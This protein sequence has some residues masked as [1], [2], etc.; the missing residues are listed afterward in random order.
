MRFNSVILPL[1]ESP[2]YRL[3]P[4][5]LTEIS[6]RGPMSGHAIRLPAQSVVDGSRF[7]VVAGR[8]EVKQWWRSFRRP[9]PARLVRAGREYDVMGRL[10]AGSERSDA[11]S[12]YL[13]ALPGSHRAVDAHTPVIAFAEVAS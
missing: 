8:P 13:V 2:A 6:Y 10:L 5:G 9:W 4:R 7:L 12:T 3:L 11:L 1:I